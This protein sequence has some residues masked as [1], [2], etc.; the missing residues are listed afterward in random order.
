MLDETYASSLET[1]NF[2]VHAVQKYIQENP[3]KDLSLGGLSE[4]FHMNPS[5][6]SRI[7]HQETGQRLS[8]YIIEVRMQLAKNMLLETN[9]RI[10][11]IAEQTGFGTVGYFTKVFH[12]YEN[13]SPKN[14]RLMHTL[15]K[16]KESN[17]K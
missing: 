17:G 8:E 16:C 7:F 4:R 9:K 12:K 1:M 2:A 3:E 14:F 10:Y 6:L 15:E 5:Y 11:E 13:C